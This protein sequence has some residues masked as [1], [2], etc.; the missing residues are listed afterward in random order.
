MYKEKALELHNKGHNCCQAVLCTFS[1]VLNVDEKTLFKIA[2]GFGAGMGDR[3]GPCG[4]LSAVTAI[5]GLINS[6]GDTENPS[7]KKSTYL[8]SENIVKEFRNRVGETICCKIKEG[9]KVSCEQCIEIAVQIAEDI[10]RR[11]S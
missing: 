9:N 6:D 11:R 4:A 8:L 10:I 1:E 3:K 7:T 5:A 2:E